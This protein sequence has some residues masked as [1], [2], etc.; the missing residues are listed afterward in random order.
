MRYKYQAR[1]K[2]GELQVGFIESTSKEAAANIL[3]SHNLFV[4]SIEGEESK[5]WYNKSGGFFNKVRFTDLV[6][7]TRQF[8]TLMEAQVPLQD[9]LRNLHKQ[10]KNKLLKEV[11]YEISSD[12]DSGL[13]LSQALEKQSA[14]FPEF[15]ISMIKSAEITGRLA[16]SMT[17]LADYLEKEAMWRSRIRNAM[18]YPIF[19][20]VIFFVVI[21]IMTVF[22]FPQLAPVFKEFNTNLPIVTT[23]IM[24]SGTFIIDWWWAI[25]FI[26]S[27]F[28]IM[29]TDYFRSNEGQLVYNQVL[30]KM[31]VFGDLFRKIYVARF[32]EITSVLVK[33]GV[34]VAQS[35]EI[36]SHSIGSPIYQEVLY[37]VSQRVRAGELLSQI[38]N[39]EEYYFPTL[40]GQMTAIGESTGQLDELLSRVSKFYTREVNSLLDNLIE[41]IQ[42]ALMLVIGIVVAI[43]FSAILLPIFNLAQGF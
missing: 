33:G 17:F 26:G 39:Q 14:V 31:P 24:S 28:T 38:L 16:E 10:T 9:S 43:L 42:P 23:I 35:I 20:I 29:M 36:A 32:A 25:I 7:F 3:T 2:E 37:N 19:V 8:S 40:I 30:M 12:I 11:I 1:T 18:I 22:V 41:L 4:L 21:I 6:V 5:H 15:Y 34:P 27:I 13:S